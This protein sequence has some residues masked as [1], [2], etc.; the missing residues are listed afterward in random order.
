MIRFSWS[1]GSLDHRPFRPSSAAFD[2]SS[3]GGDRT[4]SGGEDEIGGDEILT[5]EGEV[6]GCVNSITIRALRTV[7]A[8]MCRGVY[9]DWIIG[10]MNN[11]LDFI[12]CIDT[13][14]TVVIFH[15][16]LWDMPPLDIPG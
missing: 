14:M 6:P 12:V 10:S 16:R 9:Q 1:C 3:A 8:A 4:C 2:R 5:D 11:T 7:L 15:V 13:Y